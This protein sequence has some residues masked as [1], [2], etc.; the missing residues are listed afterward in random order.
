MNARAFVRADEVPRFALTQ[1]IG[2]ILEARRLVLL[3]TATHK[4]DAVAPALEGPIGVAAPASAVR[5]HPDVVVVLDR[6]AA[7]ALTG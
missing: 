7:G 2:T 5:R 1:G 6:E 4:A 3:A